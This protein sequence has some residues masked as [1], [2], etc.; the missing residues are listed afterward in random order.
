MKVWQRASL[1]L[2]GLF[3]LGPPVTGQIIEGPSIESITPTMSYEPGPVVIFGHNL[4]TVFRVYVDGV[5]VPIDVKRSGRLVIWRDAP[6]ADL[7][8]GFIEVR[9]DA[10]GLG[11]PT[12]SLKSLPTLNAIRH[13]NEIELVVRTG[14]AGLYA[15]FFSRERLVSPMFVPGVHYQLMLDLNPAM[16]GKIVS[17]ATLTHGPM[18]VMKFTMPDHVGLAGLDLYVQGWAQRGFTR[19][20][21][22]LDDG[23]R[24]A[25]V[26][27]FDDGAFRPRPVS[28]SFTN[29]I[30][31]ETPSTG[32]APDRTVDLEYRM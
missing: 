10:L 29:M 1:A 31:L 9:L 2:V 20:Q 7:D 28:S 4:G 17:G 12:G 13:R 24:A 14:G 23:G 11:Q 19:E 18:A 21:L 30:H 6:P 26:G 5:Q 25:W 3:A 16:A 8:P 27:D 32:V 15:V 22:S